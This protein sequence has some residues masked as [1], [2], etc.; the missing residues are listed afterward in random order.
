MNDPT[1]NIQSQDGGRRNARTRKTWISVIV[2]VLI[3]F[4]I[5]GLS[6]IAGATLW[7]RRHISTQ[8]T[9]AE[10]ATDELNRE[11]ARFAGQQPLIELHGKYDEAVVHRRTTTSP[12][13]L[14]A[15]HVLAF[16]VSAG[17]L[18]HVSIPFWILRLAPSRHVRFFHGESGVNFNSDRM[19]LTVEDLEQA[20]PGLVLDAHDPH[21]GGSVLVWLE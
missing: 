2:A 3:I 17:K 6:L 15:L 9:S 16:D 21:D 19:H 20:G 12:A 1:Q 11:R 8:F 7:I 4:V 5:L 10:V 14:Q 13:E 18:V